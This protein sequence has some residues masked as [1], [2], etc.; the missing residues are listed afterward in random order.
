MNT[1]ILVDVFYWVKSSIDLYNIS[2]VCKLWCQAC[3]WSGSFEYFQFLGEHSNHR[4]YPKINVLFFAC[5]AGNKRIVKW[6][7]KVFQVNN[8]IQHSS[9]IFALERACRNG[10][11]N[12]V[13]W[14]HKKYHFTQSDVCDRFHNSFLSACGNGHIHVAQWLHKTY[15]LTAKNISMSK[16]QFWWINSSKNVVKWLKENYLIKG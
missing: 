12:V 16:Y 13:Q 15:R 14:L 10:H 9:K 2:C 8:Y 4:C 6:I 11:L 3:Y 5:E 1:D 7:H